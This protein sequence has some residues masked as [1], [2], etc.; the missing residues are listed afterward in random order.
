MTDALAPRLLA[1]FDRHG[2]KDLPWQVEATP[3]RVWISEVMLQQT[4]VASVIPYYRRFIARF[5]ELPTL[6][7]ATLDEVLAHWSGLGYYARGRNLHRAATLVLREHGGT[8]PST[9]ADLLALPGI[10]RSTAGAILAMG[11][12]IRAPILDGNV[13]RVLARYHAEPGW[14]GALVVSRLLWALAEQH[15]PSARVGEYTQ[16]IMDLGATLCTRSRPGCER[17]PLQTD[18]RA[19]RAG[20]PSRYPAPRPR[21]E[22]PL[23][24]RHFFLLRNATGQVLLERQ[25]PVGIWGGLWSLPSHASAQD[26]RTHLHERYG[27]EATAHEPWPP[28][29]HAFT[30]FEL[31]LRPIVADVVFAT[32]RVQE[33]ASEERLWYKP[34]SAM[35]GGCPAPIERLL[36]ALASGATPITT[37]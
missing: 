28:R 36:R 19:W 34:G 22:R 11:Y 15:T 21:R 31:E 13:K 20:D 12:G 16:A 8:L 2:R 23:Q 37:S 14:P 10:G 25:A 4:Q 30:H 3:Y 32:S 33:M 26:W 24:V 18:C 27:L 1:W 29:R 7:A 6:A 35:P 5:P 17:C 9:L